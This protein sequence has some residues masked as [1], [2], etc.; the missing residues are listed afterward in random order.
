MRLMVVRSRELI[1]QR[2]AEGGLACGD[3]WESRMSFGSGRRGRS[4]G[5][6]GGGASGGGG[7][8]LGGV[9]DYR[10]IRVV[11]RKTDLK[12]KMVM[13]GELMPKRLPPTLTH[14]PG[15]LRSSSLDSRDT[16]RGAPA[17]RHQLT[18]QRL[19]DLQEQRAHLV[20]DE[21]IAATELQRFTRGKLGRQLARTV[22]RAGRV[23]ALRDGA[24]FDEAGSAWPLTRGTAAAAAAAAAAAV[25]AAAVPTTAVTAG[26]LHPATATAAAAMTR[27][28]GICERSCE[29]AQRSHAAAAT[30]AGAAG[31]ASASALSPVRPTTAPG[32]TWTDAPSPPPRRVVTP[33]EPL[34]ALPRA[35]PPSRGRSAEPRSGGSGGGL[36]SGGSGGCGSG[37]G[38]L[39]RGGSRAATAV[40]GSRSGGAQ[41]GGAPS[42][43]GDASRGASREGR[44]RSVVWSSSAPRVATS[45][46]P[47]TATHRL[48]GSASAAVL[49]SASGISCA[50]AASAAS[51][52]SG[53]GPPSPPLALP[54]HVSRSF[55]WSAHHASTAATKRAAIERPSQ[56]LLPTSPGGAGAAA[57]GMGGAGAPPSALRVRNVNVHPHSPEVGLDASSPLRRWERNLVPWVAPPP[58]AVATTDPAVIATT[59]TAVAEVGP[60]E[61]LFGMPSRPG[62]SPHRRPKDFAVPVP[63]GATEPTESPA[64]G[65]GPRHAFVGGM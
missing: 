21:V 12:G 32:P 42:R 50:S 19:F 15:Q 55:T 48:G 9:D 18:A 24:E 17:W 22:A 64:L 38:G 25:G 60:I 63:P 58:W 23:A 41:G 40:G 26:L 14:P 46:S 45:G 37:G 39:S 49:S 5:G 53:G 31:A 57:G 54:E 36:G 61:R 33:P 20:R 30:G 52:A 16:R 4:S 8:G 43:G 7:V 59:A 1:S 29:R 62:T 65:Y 47:A 11:T 3:G 28:V 2:S 44:S 6:A 56:L 10:M 27:P 35:S 34:K 51:G 13:H